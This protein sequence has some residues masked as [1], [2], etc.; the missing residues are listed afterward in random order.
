[1]NRSRRAATMAAAIVVTAV[2]T[3]VF[4]LH[5]TP[6]AQ[7]QS[8]LSS[9]W[10]MFGSSGG[11]ANGNT[12]LKPQPQPMPQPPA[13]APTTTP[14]TTPSATDHGPL[15][16][17]SDGFHWLERPGVVVPGGAFV[18]MTR[19]GT[20]TSAFIVHN[21]EGSYMLTAGHC[22]KVGDRIGVEHSN[23]YVEPVGTMVFSQFE[24]VGGQDIAMVKLSD[25][26][27][28]Q[29]NIAENTEHKD[30]PGA[31]M[32][33]I[34]WADAQWV[35]KNKPYVCRL[36]QRTGVSCGSFIQMVDKNLFQF[37]AFADQGDSGG[38]V[39]AVTDEGLV[40]LGVTSYKFPADSG[41]TTAMLIDGVMTSQNVEILVPR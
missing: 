27:K 15:F 16:Q 14:N 29:V 34:G 12:Q 1:M 10:G 2:L 20:C 39:Y 28:V 24:A 3:A 5:Q 35:A 40:A 32:K 6:S 4:C 11:N 23:G 17:R 31:G 41:K 7:A 38:P 13:T 9:D 21:D 33:L 8:S 18:N 26:S 25:L 36:G 19:N 30:Y 37:V 22:G